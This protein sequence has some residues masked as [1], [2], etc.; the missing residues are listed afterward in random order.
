MSVVRE[1]LADQIKKDNS[2]WIVR[3]YLAGPPDNL[4]SGKVFVAVWRTDLDVAAGALTHSIQ[5]DLMHGNSADDKGE[6]ALDR[7]LD[8]V[9]LSLQRLDNVTV[10]KA[11]RA[12]FGA[13]GNKWNG[14]TIECSAATENVYRSTVQQERSI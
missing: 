14:W 11:S 10:T 3:P 6:T 8:D 2:A 1:I 9:M 13:E 5:I 12:V 7:R 4:G